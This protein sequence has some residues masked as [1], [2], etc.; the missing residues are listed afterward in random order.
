LRQFITYKATLA[1]VVVVLIDPR[2]TST[3]CPIKTCGHRERGNRRS[4]AEFCCRRCGYTAPA[5][6]NAAVNIQNKA[7]VTQ[8]MVSHDDAGN[9]AGFER[10][11]PPSA[12][13]SLVLKDEAVDDTD[14]ARRLCARWS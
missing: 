11:T 3:T 10:E 2:G 13:A 9:V 8:P 4:Q 12:D 7:D 14:R 6:W 5:D 1:G